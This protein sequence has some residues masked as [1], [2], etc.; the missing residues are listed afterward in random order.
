MKK[1]YEE[2]DVQAIAAAIREKTGGADTY[3]IAQMAAAIL[4]IE[5]VGGGDGLVAG[6]F[7][8][9]SAAIQTITH[10]LGRTPSGV[11]I[12]DATNGSY[13]SDKKTGLY[14]AAGTHEGQAYAAYFGSAMTGYLGSVDITGFFSNCVIAN[15]DSQKFE[16]ALFG[17]S[18]SYAL[19]TLRE[20]HEYRWFVW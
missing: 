13:I 14:F 5:A 12:F 2:S 8:P 1:L 3:T 20:G 9:T 7:I 4:G 10:N 15:A 11:V 6:T 19:A 17:T 16:C 18:A